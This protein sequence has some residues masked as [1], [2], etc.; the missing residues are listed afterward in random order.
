MWATQDKQ[1]VVY[2]AREALL[3]GCTQPKAIARYSGHRGS[4]DWYNLL[5]GKQVQQ[6]QLRLTNNNNKN[7]TS[8]WL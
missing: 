8:D 4:I 7:T 3:D 6:S 1:S 2:R 5:G